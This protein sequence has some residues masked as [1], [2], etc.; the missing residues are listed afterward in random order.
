MQPRLKLVLDGP[1]DVAYFGIPDKT[2]S[3]AFVLV[4]A[5]H[6]ALSTN[7]HVV[8]NSFSKT[9]RTVPLHSVVNLAVD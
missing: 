9:G 4:L 2:N 6:L 8:P 3:A 7:V 5:S 1:A